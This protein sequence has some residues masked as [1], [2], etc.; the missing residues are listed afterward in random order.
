[1]RV[2]YEDAYKTL[3]RIKHHADM[4]GRR[5]ER[6]E[7]SKYEMDDLKDN[8][9]KSGLGHP[10]DVSEVRLFGMRIVQI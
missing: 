8:M 7:L 1:M 6:I 9:L 4:D 2:T 3:L 10:G 5:I